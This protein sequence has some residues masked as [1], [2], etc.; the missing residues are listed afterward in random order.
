MKLYVFTRKKTKK[1]EGKVIKKA[2]KG[3]ILKK[4]KKSVIQSQTSIKLSEVQK[5][6]IWNRF[7][8][9]QDFINHSYKNEFTRRKTK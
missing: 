4:G 8:T 9:I 2:S 1:R 6:R 7:Q 5:T 3:V